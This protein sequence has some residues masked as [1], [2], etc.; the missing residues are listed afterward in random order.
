MRQVALAAV[1]AAAF[2]SPGW[3]QQAALTE[4][5]ARSFVESLTEEARQLAAGEGVDIR[6]W[7]ERHLAEEARI[8]ASGVVLGPG[9][10]MARYDIVAGREEIVR[11][12]SLVMP[13]D[14]VPVEDYAL[15][16]DV[17]HAAPLASGQVV[18]TVRFEEAGTFRG[19]GEDDAAS[20][21]IVSSSVC[22]LRLGRVDDR[23]KIVLATCETTTTM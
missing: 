23:I 9:G 14:G 6:A 18:A 17:A 10:A 7:A 21:S 15:T 5:D 4:V 1:A 13:R 20:V 11:L 2:A 12:A 8:L 22:D 16:G 19:P 3:A